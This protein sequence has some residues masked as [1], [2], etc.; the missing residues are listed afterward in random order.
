MLSNRPLRRL[1]G[2]GLGLGSP[3]RALGMHPPVVQNARNVHDLFAPELFA[4]AQHQIV[5]LRSLQALAEPTHLAHQIGGVHTQMR[6]GVLP[7][8]QHGVPVALEVGIQQ[9]TGWAELVF[10]GVKELRFGV[11]G[12]RLRHPDQ[13]LIRQQIIVIEQGQPGGLHQLQGAVRTGA[14]V[15]VALAEHHL[16]ARIGRHCRLQQRADARVG[17][18]VVGDAELP[19]GIDLAAHRIDRRLQPLR[20][21]VEHRHQ[22]R[23]LGRRWQGLSPG[24]HRRS[25]LRCGAELSPPGL[26]IH[27]EAQRIADA[28]QAIQAGARSFLERAPHKPRRPQHHTRITPQDLGRGAQPAQQGAELHRGRQASRP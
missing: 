2:V 22:H 21:R 5:I 23:D 28:P 18:A 4:A 20:L 15:A 9:L 7:L 1:H 11:I 6:E 17:G 8:H 26:V 3:R 12:D 27:R 24:H 19:V 10:V 16:D 13:R 25:L 14:D